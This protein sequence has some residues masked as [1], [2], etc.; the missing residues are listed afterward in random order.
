MK[1]EKTVLLTGATGF[2]GSAVASEIKTKE[3]RLLGRKD[4]R[5][6]EA[7]FCPAE[8]SP[9][10]DYA[11][12]LEQVD[13]VIHA[14]ARVHVMTDTA[15]DPLDEYR[16]VNTSGTL[17]FAR[18][19]AASGVK[20]FIFISSVK[21]NGEATSENQAF[22]YDNTP[23]P[24]DYYGI[25]KAEAEA[26]LW[27]IAADTKME[28]VIIR[29]PLV[30][31]PGVKAN[32]AAMLMLAKKNLPLPLGAIHNKRSLVALDNLV[33]LIVTCIDHPKAANHTFLVSDD[34]DVSTTELLQMMTHA[35]GKKPRLI[36]VPVS[37][38]KLAGKLTGKQA[39]VDRL[40]GNLQ[41]DISHT[42]KTLGW[43]PPITV[44]EGIA[45][46]FAESE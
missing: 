41:V 23:R 36:P 5:F 29:P 35:A 16:V 38:L 37:W 8:I 20:R 3:L 10:S 30:Y 25:S 14:A 39:V 40:C 7:L 18:Q 13:V 28:V 33:D 4:P 42:K 31:G 26:G 6:T 11:T 44:E 45:R 43:K 9:L 15:V 22:R 34:Q 19:A 27:Q 46:C 24:E 1:L 12:Y 17:N 21:V 2:V 32:F